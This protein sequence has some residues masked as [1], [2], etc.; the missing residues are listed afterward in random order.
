MH[1]DEPWWWRKRRDGERLHELWG[2]ITRSLVFQLRLKLLAFII[3][4]ARN[5]VS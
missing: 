2:E 1:A 4:A 5:P 3:P